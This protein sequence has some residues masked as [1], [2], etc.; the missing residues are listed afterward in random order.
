[1]GR[2]KIVLLT[3]VLFFTFFAMSAFAEDSALKVAGKAG[4]VLVRAAG[5]AEFVDAG[6]GQPLN[7]K[8]LIKTGSDGKALLAFPNGSSFTL[9]PDTEISIEELIWNDA[10]KKVGVKMTT[11]RMRTLINKL[12]TPSEFKVTTPS[13]VCGARG[14]LWYTDVSPVGATVVLATEDSISFSNTDGSASYEVAEGY[15]SSA[16]E[17][18]NVAYPVLASPDFVSNMTKEYDIGMVAEPYEG[19]T[20]DE[21]AENYEFEP[22]EFTPEE[23][24]VSPI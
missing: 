3:A 9:K 2:F 10:A 6:V 18:G 11:G 16:D 22:P 5:T 20:G 15:T 8:D 14:T 23:P 1:M 12:D 21:G 7:P 17:N 19:P 24:V 13:A 4:K